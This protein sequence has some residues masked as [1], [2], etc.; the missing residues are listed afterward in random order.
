MQV[1]LDKIIEHKEKEVKNRIE[2]TPLKKL[3][4]SKHY[5]VKCLSMVDYLNREGASGIIAEIKRQS[6]SKGVFKADIDVEKLSI[7]YM[8]AGASALSVLTDKKF[9]GG[10]NEDLLKVRK[11]NLCP[12]L[13]KDFI[14]SDYQ[15][16]EAKAIGAD[17]ILLIASV[18]GKEKINEFTLLAKELGLEVLLEVHDE[19]EIDYYVSQI[20]LLGV[21]NR[22]LNNF[23]TTIEKSLSIFSKLPVEACLISE[24]GIRTAKDVKTLKELGY[25]GFL[26]GETFMSKAFPGKALEDLVKRLR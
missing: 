9:F 18:L 26:I 10:T 23:E 3:I 14:I 19:S 12:I 6:P 21:N 13:R 24:S 25:Q 5:N 8:Q 16:H 2:I 20:D 1:I 11:F 17:V 22:N 15:I 4:N 7:A